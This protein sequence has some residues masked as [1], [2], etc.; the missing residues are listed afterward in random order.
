MHWRKYFDERF[1]GSW[2]LEGRGDVTVTIEDVKVEELHSPNGGDD[3]KPVL[4]FKG[5]KKGMVLN[6][7]NAKTIAKL[8]GPDTDG[9][10]GKQIT[11]YATETS[12][13]G[14]QV[15]C[16]RI[17]SRIKAGA[18]ADINATLGGSDKAEEPDKTL[19]EVM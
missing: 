10:I 9:W 6:R 1:I 12:A 3:S 14:E 13:F 7:T 17:R 18:A 8:H 16:L 11:L 2:D 4:F 15:E 19:E 5:A